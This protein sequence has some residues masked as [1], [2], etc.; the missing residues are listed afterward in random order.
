MNIDPALCNAIRSTLYEC[1]G[2]DLLPNALLIY[3]RP[4]VVTPVI[5]SDLWA[6]LLY[7][8]E[9]GEVLRHANRDNPEILSWSLTTAGINRA[10]TQ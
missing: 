2:R 10:R 9:R 3:V 1:D 5:A 8:E 4:R 6:H 7:L